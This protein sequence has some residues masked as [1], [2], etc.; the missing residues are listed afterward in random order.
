MHNHEVIF[1]SACFKI[2]FLYL[3]GRIKKE[4]P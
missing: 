1:L 2:T 4:P 3:E